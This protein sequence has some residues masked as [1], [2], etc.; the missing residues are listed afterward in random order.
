MHVQY[1]Q[2]TIDRDL[3]H[4]YTKEGKPAG[5]QETLRSKFVSTSVSN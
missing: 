1:R 4:T 5:Q 3:R 2:P